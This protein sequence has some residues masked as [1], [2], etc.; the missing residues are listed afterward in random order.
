MDRVDEI[1]CTDGPI[2]MIKSGGSVKSI[3]PRVSLV[4]K[5]FAFSSARITRLSRISLE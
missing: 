5:V 1:P 4:G 3:V 2:R